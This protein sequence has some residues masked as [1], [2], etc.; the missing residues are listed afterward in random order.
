MDREDTKGGTCSKCGAW[1]GGDYGKNGN[2]E[3]SYHKC[4][5]GFKKGDASSYCSCFNKAGSC[6]NSLAGSIGLKVELPSKRKNKY[7]K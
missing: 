2:G 1:K 4:K 5:H 3:Q 7:E 6:G